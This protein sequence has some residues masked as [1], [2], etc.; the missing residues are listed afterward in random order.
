[1]DH[2]V[3]G[4]ILHGVLHETPH[5]VVYRGEDVDTGSAVVVKIARG[6]YPPPR[7]I[8]KLRREYYFTRLVGGKAVPRPLRLEMS[9][10]GFALVQEYSGRSLGALLS[11]SMSVERALG[12]AI[13]LARV[14]EEVHGAGVVHQDVNPNNV[15]VAEA[16]E[17]ND[18]ERER[19]AGAADAGDVHVTLTDFGTAAVLAADGILPGDSP[20]GTMAYIAPEQTGRMGHR[21]DHR[22]DLYSLG[23]TLFEVFA[24]RPPFEDKDPISL[25][26]SHVAVASPPLRSLVPTLPECV[27]RVVEKLL[28]KD[29]DQRYQSGAGVR[30]DLLECRRLIESGD[31]RGTFVPGVSDT[32]TGLSLPS[33]VFGRDAEIEVLQATWDSVCAGEFAALAVAA[34][35]G[36]GKT[37][38]IREAFFPRIADSALIAWSKAAR[39]AET[40]AFSGLSAL[41]DLIAGRILTGRFGPV[42]LWRQRLRDV[43]VD[44]VGVIETLAEEWHHITQW[45]GTVPELPPAQEENRLVRSLDALLTT[46]PSQD[47]PVV[48]FFDDVQWADHVTRG[49]IRR[50]VTESRPRHLLVVVAFRPSEISGNDA[51]DPSLPAFDRRLDLQ[52]LS[53]AAVRDFVAALGGFPA[54]GSSPGEKSVADELFEVSGGVPLYM[55]AAA[56]AV[57][58]SD[59]EAGPIFAVPGGPNTAID[60]RLAKLAEQTQ[61]L[62][63]TVGCLGSE[64][65]LETLAAAANLD[66]GDVYDR[67]R[68]ALRA[69]LVQEDARGARAQG[70]NRENPGGTSAT[71]R[72]AHDRIHEAAYSLVPTEHRAELHL[73]IGRRLA[74][75][76]SDHSTADQLFQAVGQMNRGRR[77]ITDHEERL[78]LAEL[79]LDAGRRARRRGAYHGAREHAAAGID[80]MGDNG[81]RDYYDL[82]LAL[83][84][85]G[86]E[87]SYLDTDYEGCTTVVQSVIDHGK[88]LL[89]QVAA[90]DVLIHAYMAQRR[91]P[92]AVAEGLELLRA[93]GLSIPQN[94]TMLHTFRHLLL[95]K[96]A[97][98]GR[99]PGSL[100][101]GPEMTDPRA[102]SALH[103]GMTVAAIAFFTR[104]EILPVLGLQMVRRSARQGNS[105][106]SAF[107]YTFYGMILGIIGDTAGGHD[108]GRFALELLE[109]F[110]SVPY[111]AKVH[112]AF[113]ALIA[114]RTTPLRDTVEPLRRASE[115]GLATGD[116]EFAALALINHVAHGIHAGWPLDDAAVRCESALQ[117]VRP[118]HQERH[119]TSLRLTTQF[120]ENL[121]GNAGDPR[122]L[123]GEYFSAEAVLPSLEEAKDEEALLELNGYTCILRFLLSDHAGAL[124]AAE[125]TEKRRLREGDVGTHPFEH[126]Y[127]SLVFLEAARDARGNRRRRLIRRADRMTRL[128]RRYA[129]DCPASHAHEVH[130]ID[131]E[132]CRIL[133]KHERATDA[134]ERAIDLARRSGMVHEEALALE[135]AGRFYRSRD[136]E[137][138]GNLYLR[139]A[140]YAYTRWGALAKTH[141]MER[142]NPALQTHSARGADLE[143]VDSMTGFAA[144][145]AEIPQIAGPDAFDAGSAVG[146]THTKLKVAD[147]TTILRSSQIL[148]REIVPERLQDRLVE[149]LME[150]AGAVAAALL[151]EREGELEIVARGRS[152]SEGS[153]ETDDI[154]VPPSIV[155]YAV[156]ADSPVVLDDAQKSELFKDDAVVRERGV[157]SALCMPITYGGRRKGVIYLENNLTPKAFRSDRLEVISLLSVQAAI[158]LENSELYSQVVDELERRRQLEAELRENEATARGLLNA[159]TDGAVLVDA[160]GVLL[161][162]NTAFAKG[163]AGSADP[164]GTS[165][166][167]HLG[168]ASDRI[169]GLFETAMESGRPE[170]LELELGDRWLDTVVYP[171]RS[172]GATRA[173]IIMFDTTDHHRTREQIEIHQQQLLQADRLASVGVLAASVAHEIGGPNHA[174]QLSA[175]TLARV[176]PDL[177]VAVEEALSDED[178]LIGG[179]PLR[180]VPDRTTEALASLQEGSRRIGIM[181]RELAGF[182]VDTPNRDDSVDAD[183]PPTCNVNDAVRGAVQLLQGYLRRHTDCFQIDLSEGLPPVQVDHQHVEQVVINLIQNACHALS[184][185]AGSIRVSTEL[186]ESHDG[187]VQLAVTDDGVGIP[188]DEIDRITEPFFT[189]RRHLGGSGLGLSISKRLV[190]SAG[191]EMRFDSVE[192]R[193]TTVTVLFPSRRF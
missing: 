37:A 82:T 6:E 85:L 90:R 171:V 122:K 34:D 48:I 106:Y 129:R 127:V 28:A 46:L 141:Q 169:R 9:D 147:L 89:D 121:R 114:H 116:F 3:G 138:F 128:L 110:D 14:L 189:T 66:T 84:N 104:P 191:G 4:C 158:S 162:H 99:G 160:S 154:D 136:R 26:H 75:D 56:S 178:L 151:L 166:W 76:L 192:G 23:A 19:G 57:L 96:L 51:H 38:L 24:R 181:L 70:L 157:R 150:A 54:H 173:A 73:E 184:T 25:M 91:L 188:P 63:A 41:L 190:E 130:L 29:P 168:A 8:E 22:T 124:E 16:D 172:P 187:R 86:A 40:R 152:E 30:A 69:G 123:E 176:V 13:G 165:L 53:P 81:W 134:Y 11:S 148:S 159:L 140:Y 146:H 113:H 119:E 180:D 64:V 98:R 94:P 59:V 80:L 174:I 182:V 27:A 74:A 65:S 61:Q 1:M 12:V 149:I 20:E 62:L 167:S 95:T 21:I 186:A 179:L 87:A 155:A 32:A 55:K 163:T 10:A 35:A 103:I 2:I 126:F 68:G 145:E 83:H 49:V 43:L 42:E 60:A 5:K 77:L 18:A 115:D 112:T 109:Q 143:G 7:E 88:N 79:N 170:H 135:L 164:A 111:R 175:E 153:R 78:N 161:D 142:D 137:R 183:T 93:L 133:D 144:A 15:L 156:Q 139:D 52:P 33:G 47:L 97:L 36:T 125:R 117:T 17:T 71:L 100:R 105:R 185:R 39:S 31:D 108:F 101:K 118:L 44:N 50:L 107:A 45:S 177:A 193:G 131:A 72:F 120:V 132:R 92:D 67:L 102:L 58:S